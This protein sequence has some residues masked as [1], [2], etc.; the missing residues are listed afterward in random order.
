MRNLFNRSNPGYAVYLATNGD[1][2]A[3]DSPKAYTYAGPSGACDTIT[4]TTLVNS[5][6]YKRTLGYTNANVTADSGWVVQA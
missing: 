2:I 5:K 6:T 3:R 1:L 4:V